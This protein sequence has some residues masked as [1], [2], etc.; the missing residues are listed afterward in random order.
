ME[1]LVAEFSEPLFRDAEEETDEGVTETDDVLVDDEK[2]GR[3]RNQF[4]LFK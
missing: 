2:V 1:D 3:I 4:L